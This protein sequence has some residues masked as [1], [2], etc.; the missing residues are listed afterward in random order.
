MF[1]FLFGTA[2]LV[3]LVKTLRGGHCHRGYGHG[4]GAGGGCGPQGGCGARGW[5]GHHGHW[6]G[7]W[8][9][10]HW[11][12]GHF[13][14]GPARFMLRGLFQRLETTPGQ[15]KVIL[16]AVDQVREKAREFKDVF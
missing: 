13:G 3:G 6:G 7:H 16:A 9:G 12:G 1:G 14:G 15:E 11:G 5:G 10:G 4:C 2:C 8:G